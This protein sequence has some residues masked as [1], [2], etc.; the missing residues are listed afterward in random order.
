MKFYAK[1]NKR[2]SLINVFDE[3]GVEY[4]TVW[5]FHDGIPYPKAMEVA[6]EVAAYLEVLSDHSF[7]F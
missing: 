2:K 6:Q 3:N 5:K 4:L 7:K 1:E